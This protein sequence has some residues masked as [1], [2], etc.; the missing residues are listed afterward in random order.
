MPGVLID[1]DGTVVDRGRAI[2][3][4]AGTIRWLRESGIPFRFATNI[5]RKPRHA[6]AGDLAA[7]G[8]DCTAHEILTA[9]SAAAK[10]LAS[11]GVRR[12]ELL[13]PTTAHEEFS[14]FQ[15][16]TPD[17]EVVVVGDLGAR[18]SF[19]NLNRAFRFLM[20]GAEL[21]AIQKNRY[22]NDVDGLSLDCGPF[23]A[24]LEYASGLTA[25]LAGKP[26]P[27]FFE[28]A[29]EE[30]GVPKSEIWMVGDDIESDVI[31]ARAAG[32]RGILV[33]TGKY[34]EEIEPRAIDESDGVIDSLSDLPGVLAP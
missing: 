25:T 34:R 23:V 24:A 9:T 31:G 4:A 29:A 21:L 11:L 8:I 33:R 27:A 16:G 17:P 32:L 26:S 6:I 18:W 5:T 28:S 7:I 14:G 3:G 22:W 30:L 13:L 15:L 2:A 10:R 12:I 20:S 19:A 1:I